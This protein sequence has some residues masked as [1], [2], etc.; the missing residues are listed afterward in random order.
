MG[1]VSNIENAYQINDTILTWITASVNRR[2]SDLKLIMIK[3]YVPYEAE[4][5]PVN[6]LM[7]IWYQNK[8]CPFIIVICCAPPSGMK[9]L[10][11]VIF[12]QYLCPRQPRWTN[13]GRVTHMCIFL[14][15]KPRPQLPNDTVS[16]QSL[17]QWFYNQIHILRTANHMV[18]YIITN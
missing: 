18:W 16:R 10:F 3:Y 4:W 14:L 5:L 13:R 1:T 17:F 11:N 12:P 7:K 9:N 6:D 8:T 2:T 15:G